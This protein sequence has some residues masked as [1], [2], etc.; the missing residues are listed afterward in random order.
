MSLFK[1]KIYKIFW[2]Y[3]SGS[4][5]YLDIIKACDI[6]AAWNKL[7]NDHGSYIT[8]ESWEEI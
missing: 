8:I 5:Q 4:A 6:A 7:K 1:K 3:Q 2:K